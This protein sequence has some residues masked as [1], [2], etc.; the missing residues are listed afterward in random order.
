MEILRLSGS[1]M[2]DPEYPKPVLFLVGPTA[3]GKTSLSLELAEHLKTEIISA[4]SRYFYR[5]MDVGTAKPSLDE[6]KR[7]VHHLIDVADP[8]DTISVAAFKERVEEII[9]RLHHQE[10]TPLVVGGTGQY[11]HS[12][13]HNWSMP[14]IEPDQKVRLVLEDYSFKNGKEKLYEFLERIDPK[15]ASI[16]DYRNVRRT[17]RAIEVILK[18]GRKFSD[19]RQTT[20]SKFSQKIFGIRWDREELY[21]R[22][23]SRIDEMMENGFI[24]EVRNLQKMGYTTKTPAMSAI[25]YR[26]IMY[27][28]HGQ[29]TFEE[30]ITLMKRNTRTFVRRQANWF[31]DN[32]PSITW[33]EGKS[34]N[35]NEIIDFIKSDRGWKSHE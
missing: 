8:N 16:I 22:I 25:G 24:E 2:L 12:I 20:N 23:D 33:F 7:I 4:D 31:K 17:I 34:L 15:A 19:L 30:A 18:T 26:E 3:S 9:N 14:Q 35:F 5:H 27:F 13:I 10:K 28:L 21:K 32:D 11:I 6:R 29:C 1:K